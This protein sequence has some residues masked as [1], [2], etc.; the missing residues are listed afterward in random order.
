M[1]PSGISAPLLLL[2]D[3]GWDEVIMVAAGLLIA[4]FVIVWTGRRK[5]EDDEN[6]DLRDDDAPEPS[7][8]SAA[9]ERPNGRQV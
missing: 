7:A 9:T 3:G 6:L 1:T 2:H 8:D 5:S 4:Y